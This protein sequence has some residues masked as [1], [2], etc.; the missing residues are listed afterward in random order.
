MFL[1]ILA[2][3]SILAD[4]T[5]DK[6]SVSQTL[7]ITS[8]SSTLH[9]EGT[10]NATWT[11]LHYFEVEEGSVFKITWKLSNV[12]ALTAKN[13]KVTI[14]V[15]SGLQLLS[16]NT[17]FLNDL[18]PSATLSVEHE[19]RAKQA[20]FWEFNLGYD[21]R[22]IAYR[23]KLVVEGQNIGRISGKDYV[24]IHVRLPQNVIVGFP[25]VTVIVFLTPFLLHLAKYRS[26]IKRKNLNSLLWWMGFEGSIMIIAI[27][28]LWQFLKRE[29]PI[30]FILW[31]GVIVGLLYFAY[32]LP[33]IIFDI[34]EAKVS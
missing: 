7:E 29:F 5:T 21:N 19:L 34:D 25:L 33:G 20:H 28:P 10:A 9:V 3:P 31:W 4:T 15:P 27:Y 30:Q 26:V 32:T 14:V 1:L 23:V 11:N 22:P 16:A 12:G 18:T 13:V 17:T 8:D 2:V 6:V 24:R